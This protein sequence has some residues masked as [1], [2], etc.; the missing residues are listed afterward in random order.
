MSFTMNKVE[1]GIWVRQERE[2]KGWLQ[3]DLA[4][5]SGLYRSIINNIETGKSRSSSDTLK[6]LANALG[7]PPNLLFE[8]VD[9]LPRQSD[10]S[11]I[12][13]KLLS[14][15]EGLPDS[16]VEIAIT[17]L[18]QRQEYYKKHPQAKPAK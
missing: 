8:F 2:K 14:I 7:Y 3:A 4:R 1:F 12:K 18:E 5:E 15:A 6:A 16:D 9:L 13:R 10:L 11:A 17:L